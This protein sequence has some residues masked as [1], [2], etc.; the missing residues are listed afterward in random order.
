MRTIRGGMNMTLTLRLL[1]VI[2]AVSLFVHFMWEML[3]S[4]AY[5]MAGV[6]LDRVVLYHLW[7]SV[8]DAALMLVLY[9]APALRR[10]DALW[11]RRPA[12]ADVGLLAALALVLAVAIERHALAAGRWAYTAAMPI[13]PGLDVGLLPV[14]QLLVLPL[15]VFWLAARLAG[16]PAGGRSSRGGAGRAE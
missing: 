10:R 15:P 2:F 7:A 6:P 13:V 14:L 12:L 9:G 1:P 5:D 8:G 3:Q 16:C 4:F 11:M